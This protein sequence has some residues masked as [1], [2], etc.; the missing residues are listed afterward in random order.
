VWNETR[1]GLVFDDPFLKLFRPIDVSIF[2]GL[3]TNLSIFGCILLI[4]RKPL[5]TV[6]MLAATILICII[7]ACS[8]YFIA[9]EPPI[10]I[11]PLAD[12]ILEST[13]YRG[14]ALLKDLFFSG[15][16]ANVMLIGLLTEQVVVKRAMLFISGLVGLLLILQHVHYSIDVLAAPFFAVLTY[17]LSVK[18]VNRWFLYE[19][20]DG[21]RCGCILQEMG[22]S[23]R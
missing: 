9:L 17:K 7:R 4:L 16:T 1:L 5:P 21:K 12:P 18:T 20:P 2:T 15:H 13:F 14:N 10:H 3:L 19:V 8:L 6:Y 11:I 23:K 22:L